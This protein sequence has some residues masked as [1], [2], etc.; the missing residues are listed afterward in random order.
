VAYTQVTLKFPFQ[1]SIQVEKKN[2]QFECV[3]LFLLPVDS[4]YF[5]IFSLL[6]NK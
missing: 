4:T 6:A 2:H 1:E 5:Y 3:N